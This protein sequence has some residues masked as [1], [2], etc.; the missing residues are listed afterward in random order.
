LWVLIVLYFSP[1][2]KLLIDLFIRIIFYQNYILS[3][4]YFIRIIF[5][6]NYILSELYFLQ[7]IILSELYFLQKIILSE[8]CFLQKIIFLEKVIYFHSSREHFYNP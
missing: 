8:L 1:F 4:L 5:Y 6:Q 7:K 3:E 2:R